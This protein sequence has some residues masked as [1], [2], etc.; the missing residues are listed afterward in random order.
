MSD[1]PAIAQRN[2]R[3]GAEQLGRIGQRRRPPTSRSRTCRSASS[4]A[5]ERGEALR[6]GVA[7]GDQI[8]RPGRGVDRGR[9][10]RP[11]RTAPRRPPRAT[12]NALMA[13]G[14]RR[15]VGAAPGAVAC[16]ARR[17][18]GRARSCARCLV[19]QADAEYALPRAHRRLHRLL[20]VDPSRHQRRQAVPPRQPAAAE[21]QVGAD[22]LPR[23]RLVDRRQRQRRS[24]RPV[25]Q[26]HAAG[27]AK[28]RASAEPRA[29]TTSWSSA[30]SSA[31]ATRSAS[32][33]RSPT[34]SRTCSASCLLN[35]W[36]ARD[37]QAWEYQPLG[38]FLVEELR[39]H[40]LAVDRD[41]GSARAVLACHS[42]APA[43]RPAAAAVPRLRQ[44]TARRRASTS[45]LEVLAPDAAHARGRASGAAR[46]RRTELPR[47]RTGPSRRWSRTTRSTAATCSPATCS[48]PARCRGPTPGPGRLAARTDGGGKQP[49]TLANG[50]T[51]TFLKTATR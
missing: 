1:D 19:A 11:G 26:T 37:I 3:P 17:R 16:A 20:H 38:P 27:R 36:S 47:T 41:A 35:D 44:P 18:G 42:D 13:L 34:P 49:I 6:G 22:R 39:D 24:A 25:G 32:R 23:P 33:S 10:R 14:P 15:V 9:V 46:S 40:D 48:A 21:L 51:R 31:R 4:A 8:A 7:I 2:P 5:P 28:R 29:S 12:L 45:Q 30:S 50:E 43:G